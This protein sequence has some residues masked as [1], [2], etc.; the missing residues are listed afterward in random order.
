MFTSLIGKAVE[1]CDDVGVETVLTLAFVAQFAAYAL[2]LHEV[3][4]VRTLLVAD[5]RHAV[6]TG[7][8]VQMPAIPSGSRAVRTGATR[9]QK[10]SARPATAATAKPGRARRPDPPEYESGDQGS[11]EVREG[12]V[13]ITV[14]GPDGEPRTK[15]VRLSGSRNGMAA[16]ARRPD[17]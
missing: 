16:P 14:I 17:D 11:E 5:D 7:T 3:D 12:T 1:V 8:V 15:V 6:E 10:G 4:A 9:D 13:R 2:P